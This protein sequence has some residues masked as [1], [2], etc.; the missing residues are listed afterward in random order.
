MDEAG[1]KV[2]PPTDGPL[3]QRLLAAC[4]LR[5]HGFAVATM[6]ALAAA[7]LSEHYGAPAML[8]AILIGLA[9]HF[10]SEDERSLLGLDFAARTMLR[11]GIACLGLRVSLGMFADLGPVM[12]ILIAVAVAGTI[13]FGILVAR[14]AGQDARFGMLT[15]G[16]VAICGASAAMAIAAVIARPDKKE[17]EREMGFVVIGVT[18]LSTLSMIFYPVIATALGLPEREIG[19]FLGATIHDVAQVAGAG[20]SV[21]VPAGE[22]AVFVKLIRVTMLAPVVLTAVLLF[23][24]SAPAGTRR[25]PLLPGFVIVF[26][27]LAALNSVVTVP[28]VI[29]DLAGQV[30]RWALLVAIAAVGVKTSLASISKVGGRAI[31]AL[32]ADTVFLAVFVLVAMLLLGPE[33]IGV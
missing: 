9:L 8:L 29:T 31:S 18:M 2:D 33:R 15:G 28:P 19:M 11:F 10:L 24:Q 14:F 17:A 23:R 12:L 6:I 25:P 16:A 13:A 30:S 7:F 22:T 1:T 5:F 4:R 32:V 21:S 26:I 3:G 20:F 27:L